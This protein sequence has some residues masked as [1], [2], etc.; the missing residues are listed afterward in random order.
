VTAVLVLTDRAEVWHLVLLQLVS[1]T[2]FAVSYPAFHGMVPILLPTEQRKA[3][4]LLVGQSESAVGIVGPALS[5]VLVA[6]AGPGWALAA[7]AATYVVAPASW[8]W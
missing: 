4:Y 2:V 6:T 1:G 5:G 8:P 7:D 3:A